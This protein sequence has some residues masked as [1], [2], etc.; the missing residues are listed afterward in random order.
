MFI[1]YLTMEMKEIKLSNFSG[2]W[3][4][5]MDIWSQSNPRL[6]A[7]GG[8]DG[9]IRVWNFETWKTTSKL[10]LNQHTKGIASLFCYELSPQKESML[11]LISGGVDG[12]ITLWEVH[13]A[14]VKSSVKVGPLDS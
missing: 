11:Y 8:S 6:I 4:Q 14:S 12:R 9:T 10:S 5:S 2:K 3:Q 1:D 7:F 13:S